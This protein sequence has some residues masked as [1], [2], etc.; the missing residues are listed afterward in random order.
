MTAT[1]PLDPIVSE[2]E[3]EEQA[4]AY[5]AW[6]KAKVQEA[7]ES[8]KPAIPHDEMVRRMKERLAKLQRQAL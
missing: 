2:F 8:D 3:T 1:T 7:M 5:D 6:F 4:A